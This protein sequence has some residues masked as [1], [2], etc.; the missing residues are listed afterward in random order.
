MNLVRSFG[1]LSFNFAHEKTGQCALYKHEF[2]KFVTSARDAAE[3]SRRARLFR[4]DLGYNTAPFGPPFWDSCPGYWMSPNE[5]RIRGLEVLGFDFGAEHALLAQ[6]AQP[7]PKPSREFYSQ[8]GTAERDL[9][10]A[11]H[12]LP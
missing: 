9:W 2:L 7:G 1:Y 4:K 6:K 10:A 8:L 5:T 12:W 11:A 3:S